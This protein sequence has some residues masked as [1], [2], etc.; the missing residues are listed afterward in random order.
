ML[1][2]ERLLHAITRVWIAAKRVG[3]KSTIGTSAISFTHDSNGPRRIARCRVLISLS[4]VLWE[5]GMSC[6]RTWFQGIFVNIGN[7]NRTIH[8]FTRSGKLI[9]SVRDYVDS[10]ELL[11]VN[12][13]TNW[14]FLHHV[15]MIG[16]TYRITSLSTD[17]WAITINQKGPIENVKQISPMTIRRFNDQW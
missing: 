13:T 17:G 6:N 7:N 12:I 11:T 10:E 2:C 9:D 1:N 15:N 8:S 16:V 4:R 5:C 14:E 3:L